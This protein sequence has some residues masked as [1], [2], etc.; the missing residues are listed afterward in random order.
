MAKQFV[1]KEFDD[2]ITRGEKMVDGTKKYRKKK[3]HKKTLPTRLNANERSRQLI[4][5]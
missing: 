4:A 2:L 5:L 1:S 3:D